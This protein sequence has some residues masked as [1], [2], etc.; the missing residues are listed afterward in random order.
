MDNTTPEDHITVVEDGRLSGTDSSLR[1]V[2]T[3]GERG[4]AERRNCRR[5]GGR[6]IA[7]FDMD[8]G[9]ALDESGIEKV[10]IGHHALLLVE[11]FF[12]AEQNSIGRRIDLLNVETSA[13]GN[14][15]TSALTGCVEGNAVVLTQGEPGFIDKEAGFL[16]RRMF[17]LDKG[18]IVPLGHETNFLAFFELIW[19]KA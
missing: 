13:G 6:R 11:G 7:K 12:W 8:L 2:K 15:E 1:V 17:M 10:E 5:C 19:R 9:F 18:P 3:D 14:A 16:S 4:G